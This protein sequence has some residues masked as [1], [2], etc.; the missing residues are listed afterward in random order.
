MQ[1]YISRDGEQNGPYSIEDVN[2]YLKDGALLP[3]DLACQ[4][5]MDEWVPISQIPGVTMQE[6]NLWKDG[7]LKQGLRSFRENFLGVMCMSTLVLSV[8]ILG[9]RFGDIYYFFQKWGLFVIDRDIQSWQGWIALL[10]L[11]IAPLIIGLAAVYFV[12][13]NRGKSLKESGVF[14]G[15]HKNYSKW[16]GVVWILY[17]VHLFWWT[18][19]QYTTNSVEGFT[20][21]ASDRLGN[22][23]SPTEWIADIASVAG[24]LTVFCMAYSW[25]FS[26]PIFVLQRTGFSSALTVSRKK[27]WKRPIHFLLFMFV[28]SL[29]ALII[30]GAGFGLTRLIEPSSFDTSKGIGD[31]DW[32]PALLFVIAWVMCTM[33][34][35]FNSMFADVLFDSNSDTE[36]DGQALLSPSAEQISDP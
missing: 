6:Y 4:E 28:V 1:I 22:Y 3:T 9:A 24:P 23:D 18:L 30:W 19:F 20:P 21:P 5:G 27:A 14:E 32:A 2:A 8:L 35:V 31:F 25:I 34:T 7:C 29:I 17:A 16:L 12:Q 15:F 11:V 36:T 13:I 33:G 10:V 26:I